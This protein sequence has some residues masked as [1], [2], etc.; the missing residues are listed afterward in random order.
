MNKSFFSNPILFLFSITLILY[1]TGCSATTRTVTQDEQLHYDA[2]YDFTDKEKIVKNLAESLLSKPPLI[3]DFSRPVIIIYNVTNRTS[4]HISTA[5]ITD[6]IR[7]ELLSSGKV[8]F[9]NMA[10]RENI[11]KES[12]YQHSGQVSSE[13]KIKRAK[14]VGAKYMLSGTLRSME[15]KQMKQVRIKKKKVK[16]YSLNLELTDIETSL[17]EWADNV[18]IIREESKPFIGW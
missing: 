18:E 13:T 2:G 14:Q 6:N 10:G 15:K 16:Y 9:V 11:S 3:S 8:R 1:L 5:G 12:A 17:I 4:E 7:K